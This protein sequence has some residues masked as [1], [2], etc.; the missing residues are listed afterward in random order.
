MRGARRV[1]FYSLPEYPHFYPEIVNA[2][3]NYNP[4]GKGEEVEDMMGGEDLACLV[5]TSQLEKMALE[6]VIGP[7]RAEHM[8]SSDKST[9]VFF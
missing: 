7:K 5:L 8:L 9:F 4:S 2:L 3:S 1:I 6:R